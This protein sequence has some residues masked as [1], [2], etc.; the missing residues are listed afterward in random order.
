MFRGFGLRFVGSRF[1]VWGSG[2]RVLDSGLGLGFWVR[3]Q[4]FRPAL[5]GQEF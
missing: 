4:G 2:F 3:G 5:L 1:R